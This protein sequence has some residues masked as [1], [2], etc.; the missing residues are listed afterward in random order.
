MLFGVAQTS[1]PPPNGRKQITAYGIWPPRK[2]RLPHQG[3]VRHRITENVYESA[4]RHRSSRQPFAAPQRWIVHLA[5]RGLGQL[6]E[7]LHYSWH[8]VARQLLGAMSKQIFR[9]NRRA[10]LGNHEGLD[11]L[12]QRLIWYANH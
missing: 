3:G 8:H 12:A 11:G 7:R 5:A 1:F 6:F 4:R 10:I 2:K 9:L